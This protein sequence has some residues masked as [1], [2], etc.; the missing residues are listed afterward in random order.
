MWPTMEQVRE[1]ATPDM[2]EK[3]KECQ[4]EVL[5][6]DKSQ[7]MMSSPHW[8]VKYE[9]R[10]HSPQLAE[11]YWIWATGGRASHKDH[12]FRMDPEILD[13]R[14]KLDDHRSSFK[15]PNWGTYGT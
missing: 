13:M 4:R 2:L 3:V 7:Y 9:M 10:K 12:P 1:L 6:R 11:E 14:W 15:M 5:S 8:D